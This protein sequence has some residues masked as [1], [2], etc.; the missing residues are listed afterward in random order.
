MLPQK[1]IENVLGHVELSSEEA[2]GAEFKEIDS[3]LRSVNP[4]LAGAS[5][6]GAFYTT[7]SFTRNYKIYYLK[8]PLD[9]YEAKL[10]RDNLRKKTYI[11]SFVKLS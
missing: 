4:E 2:S 10:S 9:I 11:V 8:S 5:Y 3:L 6:L 1:V 7:T